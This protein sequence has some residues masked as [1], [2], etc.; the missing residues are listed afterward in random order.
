MTIEYQ[1]VPRCEVLCKKFEDYEVLTEENED[2]TASA[3]D[4]VDK[5]RLMSSGVKPILD[6]MNI[7]LDLI[8][9]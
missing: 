6:L 1:E 5:G 9:Q 7:I 4:G 3:P 2:K 8:Y